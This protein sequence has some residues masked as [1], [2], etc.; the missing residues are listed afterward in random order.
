MGAKNV[1]DLNIWASTRDNLSLG[2]PIKGDSN[3]P[4]QLQILARKLKLIFAC[5]KFRYGT[6]QKANNK[7][8][9]QSAQMRR[10]VCAFVA[11]KPRKTGFLASRPIW[12]YNVKINQLI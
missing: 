4:V 3:Q 9:D 10:L 7:G 11:R 2:F 5:S 6:F 1:D 12:F 8:A